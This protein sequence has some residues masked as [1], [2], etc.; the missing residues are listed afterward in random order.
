MKTLL[1]TSRITYVP[2]NYRDF[3][4]CLALHPSVA[5]L[6]IVDNLDF[7]LLKT[8]LGLVWLG[9]FRMALQIFKNIFSECLRLREKDYKSIGKNVYHLKELNSQKFVELAGQHDLVLHSRTRT[10]LT[11]AVLNAPRFGCVNVHHGILPLQ[12]GVLCDLYAIA[13]QKI[14]NDPGFSIHKMTSVLDDGPVFRVQK[15]EN[16]ER[17]FLS[18]L[19]SGACLEGKCV[20]EFLSFVMKH[21][22][23]PEG[24][25]NEKAGSKM[26]R[27]PDSKK[28]REWKAK[29]LKI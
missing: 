13:E 1:V 27:T 6:V 16:C 10:F 29:G 14:G 7:K 24:Q 15:R 28:M 8:L 4:S 5:C 18:Y 11:A 12:R 23:L 26:Y 19:K 25:Q 21:E 3:T 20:S 2:K 22:Q 9:A 17:N